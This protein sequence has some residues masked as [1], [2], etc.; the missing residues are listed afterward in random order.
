M[1]ELPEV[2][3]V[4]RG[5]IPKIL[6]KKIA[7]VQVKLPRI[8]LG[9]T[10]QGFSR[11]FKNQVLLEIHR[12]GKYL[13]FE[14]EKEAFIVHLGMTGQLMAWEAK[15]VAK[16]QKVKSQANILKTVTGMELSKVPLKDKHTH[17]V[18]EWEG[19]GGLFFRDVRTFGKIIYTPNKNWDIHPRIAKLGPEPIGLKITAFLKTQFPIKNKRT[20][21]AHLLDQAFIAGLGNIYCD[22]ALF[23]SKIHPETPTFELSQEQWITLLKNSQQVLKKGIRNAGTTFSDYRTPSGDKGSNQERLLVYGRGGEPCKKC[24]DVLVK[25]VVAQRGTVFCPRCQKYKSA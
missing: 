6:G 11:L 22:E 4:K 14:W 1:P 8:L 16:I 25:T 13:I 9:K 18:L 3:T 23:L 10:P 20:V 7:R 17:M 5:L 24:E 2:E 21:K 19:G 12:R 15:D